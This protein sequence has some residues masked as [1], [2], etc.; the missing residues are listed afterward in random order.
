[1][2]RS[3]FL[4]LILAAASSVPAEDVSYRLETVSLPE[5]VPPEVG[6]LGF[7]PSGTLFVALRRSDVL[8]A[9]PKKDPS[10]FGWK[11]FAS[12]LHNACGMVVLSDR[13][14]IVSQMAE[15]TR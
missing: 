7:S 12:G 1:M 14:I 11:R 2:K 10:Q 4:S 9:I 6:A 5:G 13:E 3:L 15:L 8:T